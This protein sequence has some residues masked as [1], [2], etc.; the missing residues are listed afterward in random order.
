M[1]YAG[2]FNLSNPLV[3]IA[4]G[5]SY[6]KN[7]YIFKKPAR[8]FSTNREI[9]EFLPNLDKKIISDIFNKNYTYPSDL[10]VFSAHV[11]KHKTQL[12]DKEFGYL[13]AG[14]IEADG[15]FDKEHL[16]I[17]FDIEDITLAYYIKKKIGYGSVKINKKNQTN[18]KKVTYICSNNYGLKNFLQLIK[19]KLITKRIFN[20]LTKFNYI[21]KSDINFE[22]FYPCTS[23]LN[24]YNY[25]LVGY[26][27]S[28]VNLNM[29][30]INNNINSFSLLS[31]S[32]KEI[33]PNK[34]ASMDNLKFNFILNAILFNNKVDILP[35]ILLKFYIKVGNIDLTTNI[36]NNES[37]PNLSNFNA[38]IASSTKL[39]VPNFRCYDIK[40]AILIINYLKKFNLFGAKYVYYLKF[41]KIYWRLTESRNIYDYELKKIQSIIKKGSSETNRKNLSKIDL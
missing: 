17:N 22:D 36:N 5:K 41:R 26:M 19:G 10:P 32:T 21:L 20:Q 40:I 29:S 16:F 13:L 33:I 6:L 11:G 7:F 14:L 27:Q 34:K 28:K 8:N 9:P 3:F 15:F 18:N 2:N 37:N 25:W 38:V 39:I 30:V 24:F 35:L 4:L 1:Q 31:S 12:S 23:N